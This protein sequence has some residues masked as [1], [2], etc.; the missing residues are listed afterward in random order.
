MRIEFGQRFGGYALAMLTD[1]L[2]D[3][4][5][6][7]G[8]MEALQLRES[9]ATHQAPPGWHTRHSN[10]AQGWNSSLLP[11]APPSY[12]HLRRELSHFLGPCYA[13]AFTDETR[14][15][16]FPL[17]GHLAALQRCGL[18]NSSTPQGRRLL[19]RVRVRLR[20]GAFSVVDTKT[21]P[22]RCIF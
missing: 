2:P 6:V 13:S 22:R 1:L 15:Y 10:G 20:K 4:P 18:T 7:I 3:S 19:D 8:S 14:R 21:L 11:E 5:M 9:M 12:D 17:F 16:R